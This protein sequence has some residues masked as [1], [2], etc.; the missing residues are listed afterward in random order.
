LGYNFSVA[1]LEL[2]FLG[3]PLLKIDGSPIDTD[4]RKALA[5]LAYLAVA[6]KAH[7]RE[8]L[9]T[10]LWPD[11]DRDSAYAYLRHTL[12]ELNNLL[13]KGWIEA[14]R[15]SVAL[16]QEAD[17]WL[18]TEIFRD[19]LDQYRQTATLQPGEVGPLVDAVALY[20][21][22]FLAGF[23]LYDSAAFDDWQTQQAESFR[24]DFAGALENL[25]AG[26]ADKGEPETA[27]PF[28][29]RW[30]ALDPLDE[31]AH[32]A[33]MRLYAGMEDRAGAVRQYQT[34]VQILKT[35]LDVPPQ[36]ETTALYEQIVRGEFQGTHPAR[37]SPTLPLDAQPAV[38]EPQAAAQERP[39]QIQPLPRLPVPSTSFIGRRSELEQIKGLMRSPACRLLTLTGPGGTGKTRLAIQS[40]T[41]IAH[42]YPDGAF[43]VPLD[44]LNPGEPIVSAIAKAL[45]FFF[46]QGE[47]PPQQQLLDY[48][49][50][51]QALLVLDN[52]EHLIDRGNLSLLLDLLETA[53]GVKL[54]ATSRTRLNLQGE[55][56]F[57]VSG[58]ETPER[59]TGGAL[60]NLEAELLAYSALELFVERARQVQPGFR[61]AREN[62]GSV[63]QICQSVEGAPLG[64]ELAAAWLELLSPD[65]IYAEIARSLDFLETGLEGVPERQRS[66]RAVFESSWKFLDAEERAAI[67]KMS[68]FLGSFSRQAAQQVS[69]ASLRAL[70][71]LANKSWLEV[72]GDERFQLHESL[73]GYANELLRADPDAWQAA[74]DAHALFYAG[75][76]EAQGRA[77]RGSGQIA[78][79]DA[80]AGEFNSNIRTAL[81]WLIERRRF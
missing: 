9:A 60:D 8:H 23:H 13:G 68:V 59:D 22:D 20:R 52:F 43:F 79:L 69:G 29:R 74:R 12:W 6:G 37:I 61:L 73:R 33:L 16:I 31:A 7:S 42:E 10:L 70:L 62:L 50:E 41:E 55:Q 15:D 46:Y 19:L 28:A 47:A 35:E 2:A 44:T 11:F 51:K 34:C 24:R 38:L 14:D 54:L 80:I 18:D 77:L 76:I 17:L 5:L 26:Y 57:P 65:E 81:S 53:K 40:A 27:L 48:L 25:A 39:A 49:R 32:Q 36:P 58:L 1:R 71:G 30:L 63:I 21:E 56:L 64:I 66:L 3:P 67:Q 45:N 78:A 72:A 75:F 4:R